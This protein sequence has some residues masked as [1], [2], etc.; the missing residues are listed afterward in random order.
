ME[1][2]E[3]F[4]ETTNAQ[5]LCNVEIFIHWYWHIQKIHAL[6]R[7]AFH[8]LAWH[9]RLTAYWC[10][11]CLSGSSSHCRTPKTN[12]Y[13]EVSMNCKCALV[14]YHIN[15]AYTDTRT[16]LTI[17][18]IMISW[19]CRKLFRALRRCKGSQIFFK[20]SHPHVICG[21]V[22]GAAYLLLSSTRPKLDLKL[23]F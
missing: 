16:F 5:S 21:C 18:R 7:D 11:Q 12:L 19:F 2:I 13:M 4:F 3:L 23:T 8:I 6:F 14:I 1:L 17:D 9:C 15:G 20:D 22:Y 10:G